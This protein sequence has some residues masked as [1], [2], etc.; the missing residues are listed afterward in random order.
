MQPAQALIDDGS[1]SVER[2]CVRWRGTAPAPVRPRATTIAVPTSM[3]RAVC[4]ELSLG[5]PRSAQ[6]HHARRA[7][8]PVAATGASGPVVSAHRAARL[9]VWPGGKKIQSTVVQSV[10]EQLLASRA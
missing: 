9:A 4:L 7:G 8:L 3:H 5:P 6:H 1:F 10:F 2:A